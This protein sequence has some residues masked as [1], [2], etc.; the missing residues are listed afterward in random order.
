MHRVLIVGNPN[1]GK[2][3][4]FN[5]LTKSNEHTGNFHGVTVE[6]KSKVDRFENQDYEFV[7]LPGLYSLNS[8]SGE[9]E[10]AKEI[11]LKKGAKILMI[12]D[13]N[14]IRK[15]L[16]L[17][18]QLDEIGINYKIIINNFENFK[19]NGNNIDLNLLKNKLNKEI[20]NLNAK[21]CKL[22]KEIINFEKENIK[23]NYFY[24]EKYIKIVQ[25]KYK[26]DKKT[27]IFAL[28]GIF[29][30]LKDEEIEFV[31]S[32]ISSVIKDRY[33]FIDNQIK[34]CV[35][36][37]KDFVYGKSKLDKVLLNP[38]VALSVFL[39]TFFLGFYFIFFL[40]G[41]LISSL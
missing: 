21:K 19:K 36:I 11:L 40:V 10:V 16:Y 28:N 7:D 34:D 8:F 2:S 23:N 3:T 18:Q 24:L 26:I 27:I 30:N 31:K 15:N 41:P 4:L 20:I 37:K 25:N 17:C 35:Q 14:S 29:L 1:V 33:S 39:L 6:E 22:N 12:L 38:F 5:S 32:L 9:E 13:A